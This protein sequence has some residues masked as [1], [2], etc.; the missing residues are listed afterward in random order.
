MGGKLAGTLDLRVILRG[1][2][3]PTFAAIPRSDSDEWSLSLQAV[4]TPVERV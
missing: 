4:Q 1:A 2:N 3:R